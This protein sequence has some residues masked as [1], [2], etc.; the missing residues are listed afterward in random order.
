V[1]TL[2]D[3]ACGRGPADELG[4]IGVGKM[5]SDNEAWT[6]SQCEVSGE[7]PESD[8]ETWVPLSVREARQGRER[9]DDLWPYVWWSAI[10]EKLLTRSILSRFI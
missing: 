3:A 1:A 10:G 6:S 2:A 4:Q 9:R 7:I 5:G 8:V